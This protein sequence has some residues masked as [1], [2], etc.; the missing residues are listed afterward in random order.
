MAKPSRSQPKRGTRT[1]VETN[2]PQAG[3]IEDLIDSAKSP[4]RDPAA[5]EEEEHQQ[6]LKTPS[7]RRSPKRKTKTPKQHVS[8]KLPG[9]GTNGE[10][11]SNEEHN[12]K[13][14][15]YV[16][17]LNRAVK[18]SGLTSPSEL[19]RVSTAGPSPAI[20]QDVPDEEEDDDDDDHNFP[21][22]DGEESDIE[23]ALQSREEEDE[24]A[25]IDDN[26]EVVAK[27]AAAKDQFASPDADFN[28]G[29]NEDDSDEGD[30]LAPPTADDSSDDED[31]VPPTEEETAN[32]MEGQ[33]D[34]LESDN[35]INA[36]DDF[37]DHDD[38]E[39]GPGYNMVHDPETPE[40]VRAARARKEKEN[41]EQ[42]KGR[43]KKRRSDSDTEATPKPKKGKRQ[44]K[45]NRRVAFSP[46]GIQIGNRDYDHIPIAAFVEGSPQDDSD[47][48]GP[49]RSSRAKLKPLEYWRGEKMEYGAHEEEGYVGEAFGNMPVVKEIRK[50]RPTP[51][52]KKKVP[53]SAAGKKKKVV[54]AKGSADEVEFDSRKLRRKYKYIDGEEAYLWDDSNEDTE[55]ISYAAKMEGSQLPL[56]PQ[57]R[58]SEGKVTG[59][60]AQAFNTQ[61]PEED[62]YVGYIMGNLVLPPK[63]IKDSESVG[64]CSQTFTVCACQPKAV[65]VAYG[66]PDNNGNELDPETAQRF[67]LSPGDLFR[68]P[69]GNSYRLENHSTTTECLFT[70]T[71]IRPKAVQS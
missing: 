16:S 40:A 24:K 71:I 19:S 6:D 60:A 48:D 8:M 1:G 27:Q 33:I 17:K 69:P 7:T 29:G 64:P 70:W 21:A 54:T 25:E 28:V 47:R 22:D 2:A 35:E 53:I 68:V 50:A 31:R 23:N 20:D 61:Y 39:E 49:R 55:V 44:K 36:N 63:G 52:K 30:P 11:D 13:A 51:Y 65:E 18:K 32:K 5:E 9:A 15:N 14:K 38:E 12:R 41:M 62:N 10:D 59:Q 56:P 58:K 46:K 34:G 37:D 42:R 3:S 66:D 43:K 57:R 67:F 45:S 26:E 4:A